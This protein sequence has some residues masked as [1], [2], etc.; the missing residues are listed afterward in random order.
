MSAREP[1][2]PVTPPTTEGM[3]SRDFFWMWDASPVCMLIHDAQTKEILWANAAAC[4]MLEFSVT[5]LK[6]LKAPDMSSPARQYDRAIGLAWLQK[7]VDQGSSSIEW[8]YRSRSGRVIPTEAIA[9][10]VALSRGLV[11]MVQFR[12]IQRE[13]TVRRELDITNSYVSAIGHHA[14]VNIL[15]LDA[16]GVVEYATDAALLSLSVPPGEHPGALADLAEL[17]RNDAPATW[18][19]IR[20]SAAPVARLRIAVKRPV[21]ADVWLEGTVERLEEHAGDGYLVVLQDVSDRVNAEAHRARERYRENYLAR[22]TAMGDMAM[23]IAHELG[24]PLSAASNFLRG[25]TARLDGVEDQ[26]PVAEDVRSAV[27][28]ARTQIDRAA[29][30][31][32]SVR[33]FVGHQEQDA[34]VVDLRS[35]VDECGYFVRLRAKPVNVDVE[36]VSSG[37]PLLVCCE[38]VLIGQVILNLCFNAIEELAAADSEPRRLRVDVGESSGVAMVTVTDNGRGIQFDP[39]QQ[40]FA[41][42]PRG[43]GIGLI[44]SQRIVTRQGGNIWAKRLAEGGSEFGFAL[45]LTVGED[46]L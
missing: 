16:A 28:L 12:D 31:V 6:P 18:E 2:L 4:R 43:S 24:Q 35:I 15:V 22:Y 3:E 36:V 40:S 34:Q 44:L 9:T 14:S 46:D 25:V 26:Q 38:R 1:A 11:V 27:E 8:H 30:V 29:A 23:A 7:A 41:S 10:R 42:R 5:E 37:I 20:D 19:E 21:D 39:F 17:H 13:L 45:P 33:S 32:G